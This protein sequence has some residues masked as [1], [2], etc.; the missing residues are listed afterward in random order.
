PEKLEKFTKELENSGGT[1]RRIAEK[2]L[3][4]LAGSW[5]QLSG[6]IETAAI[7]IGGKFAPVLRLIADAVTAVTNVFIALPAPVQTVAAVLIGLS[8]AVL[9]VG[10]AAAFILPKYI[11]LRKA[12]EASPALSK[13]ASAAYL[14]LGKAMRFFGIQSNIALGKFL[15]IG[16]GIA[17]VVLAIQDLITYI[18]GGDSVIGRT[19]ARVTPLVQKVTGFMRE[20]IVVVRVAAGVLGFLFGPALIRAAGIMIKNFALGIWRGIV[21][22]A[23]FAR[24]LVVTSF[25]VL[26]FGARL[27]WAGLRAIAPFVVQLGLAIAKAALFGLKLYWVAIKTVAVFVKNLVVAAATAIPSMIAGLGSAIASGTAF[28]A[29]LLACPLTWII[30]AIVALGTGIYFLIRNWDWVTAAVGRAWNALKQWAQGKTFLAGPISAVLTLIGHWDQV[31]GAIGRAWAAVKNWGSNLIN[32]ILEPFRNLDIAQTIINAILAVPQKIKG[33]LSSLAQTIRDFL[34]FSPAK[35]GPLSDLDKVG[36]GLAETISS[37]LLGS[38][39]TIKTAVG[40]FF[41]VVPN[42]LEYGRQATVRMME[43][44]LYGGAE[45]A[46]AGAGA[47]GGALYS[48]RMGGFTFAPQITVNVTLQGADAG[49]VEGARKAGGVIADQVREAVFDLFRQIYHGMVVVNPEG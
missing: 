44:M 22:V 17:L 48:G 2:Q 7:I 16:A 30:G 40:K 47:A 21:R 19:I 29:V 49:T 11:A 25:R 34:P 10:T 1:A 4:N 41:S 32:T 28:N 9:G 27:L 31:T 5:E 8:V 33:A 15:L 43:A 39:D 23:S 35:I 26:V 37:G 24:S 18:R 12:I 36:P 20:H 3:D 38:I 14:R 46:M 45:P 42:A 13:L 6:S